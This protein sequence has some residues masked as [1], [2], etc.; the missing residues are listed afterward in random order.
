MRYGTVPIVRDVGG[1]HDTVVDG[2]T[3]IVFEKA[4]L[5]ELLGALNRAVELYKG[6]NYGRM[7]N[8]IMGA[9]WS[10]DKSASQYKDIYTSLLNG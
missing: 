7:R 2:E 4:D 1:L 9:D 6:E 10:W 3:G 8:L 5:E